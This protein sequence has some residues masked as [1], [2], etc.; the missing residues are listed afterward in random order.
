VTETLPPLPPGDAWR[1]HHTEHRWVAAPCPDPAV[2]FVLLSS[3]TDDALLRSRE[4]RFF[5]LAD[6]ARTLQHA[7]RGPA[8]SEVTER[9]GKCGPAFVPLSIDWGTPG[10][11]HSPRFAG[12]QARHRSAACVSASSSLCVLDVDA[13]SELD[14]LEALARMEEAGVDY[15]SWT[16]H[17]HGRS[18]KTGVYPCRVV[19][20]LSSPVPM[21]LV[22]P[23]RSR[24]AEKYALRLDRK[25]R[26]P[27]RLFFLPSCP[28]DDARAALAQVLRPERECARL[29]PY[30]LVSGT[31]AEPTPLRMLPR[32]A[33][34][35]AG[36]R[37]ALTREEVEAEGS[38]DALAVLR[39]APWGTP[40]SPDD[41]ESGR[42]MGLFR[43]GGSLARKYPWLDPSGTAELFSAS[44]AAISALP[45][46][47]AATDVN[48][49]AERLSTR[50]SRALSEHATNALLAEQAREVLGLPGTPHTQ[51]RDLVLQ[52]NG[53]YFIR[54]EDGDY[55]GPWGRDQAVT[56]ARDA[57][58]D[59]PGVDVRTPKGAVKTAAQLALDYGRAIKLVTYDYNATRTYAEGSTMIAACLAPTALTPQE[60]PEIARWLELLGGPQHGLLLDWLA[61]MRQLADPTAGLYLCA[62]PGIGKSMLVLG[63]ARLWPAVGPSR[64][65]SALDNFNFD[66][67]RTPLVHADEDLRIEK[68][69]KE[70]PI[71]ALK[72]LIDATTRQVMAK[73]SD[74]AQLRG[75]QRVMVTVNQP[76]PELFAEPLT[77]RE[78]A[79]L[80]ERVLVL[81]PRAADAR[82]YLASLGGRAATGAWVDGDGIAR[83]VL[84]LE[85]TRTVVPGPRYLVT[86]R[87]FGAVL[88]AGDEGSRAVCLAVLRAWDRPEIVQRDRAGFPGV[89]VCTAALR[90]KWKSFL[91]DTPL[92]EDWRDACASACVRGDGQRFRVGDG[93]SRFRQL[94]DD[95]LATVRATTE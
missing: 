53:H 40:F 19:V 4:H 70:K 91:P 38:V 83:H 87:G 9:P 13:Q 72:R 78:I 44:C 63:L 59:V 62:D 74:R 64:F 45:P 35:H 86:G 42:E 84:W 11:S 81:E 58:A 77:E 41:P 14:V 55:D 47:D 18:D 69:H 48:W 94:R 66:V 16:T 39:G 22:G 43:L 31:D 61:T 37:R 49:V 5:S 79:A 68:W 57:L 23:L 12:A 21:D 2:A 34:P 67:T 7:R 25:T 20:P 15:V 71:S 28:D 17:S 6:F 10:C 1:W 73:Y 90:E 80:D 8:G 24:L 60:S 51:H 29:D 92:P 93:Q 30:S 65:A 33:D 56:A 52:L 76:P 46:P 75:A 3:E 26:D 36:K 89:W 82:S 54:T 27:G 95:V 50:V 32:G 85:Q 88:G